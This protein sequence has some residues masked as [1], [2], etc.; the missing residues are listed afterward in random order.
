MEAIVREQRYNLTF[1]YSSRSHLIRGYNFH[2]SKKHVKQKRWCP[3]LFSKDDINIFFLVSL[4]A[5]CGGTNRGQFPGATCD[6]LPGGCSDKAPNMYTTYECWPASENVTQLVCT[7]IEKPCLSDFDCPGID[8]EGRTYYCDIDDDDIFT[9]VCKPQR[10]RDSYVSKYWKYAKGPSMIRP[11][12]DGG[13]HSF[14]CFVVLLLLLFLFLGFSL[15]DAR[16]ANI[17][18]M[19]CR[20]HRKGH[21]LSLQ[22]SRMP[23][24]RI[25]LFIYGFPYEQKQS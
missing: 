19:V 7:K 20:L 24:W 9:G 21:N 23:L 25:G 13:L 11:L 5:L 17:Y 3:F 10:F 4:Q 22:K 2:H 8:E 1:S 12:P 18:H 16:V 14:H 6:P 15:C